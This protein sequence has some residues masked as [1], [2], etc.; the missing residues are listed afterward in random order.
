M[1]FF[2]TYKT[3]SAC[4][5]AVEASELLRGEENREIP[6]VIEE[7][8]EQYG[9]LTRTIKIIN[10]DGAKIMGRGIGSY[11]TIELPDLSTDTRRELS[12][13][14]ANALS[15]SLKPLIPTKDKNKPILLVGLGN[16]RMTA[17]ALGPWSIR[18]IQPTAHLMDVLPSTDKTET[19]SIAALIPGVL[20]NTGISTF[21]TVKAVCGEIKPLCVVAVDALSTGSLKR[22]GN[23]IQ[24]ADTGIRPGSGISNHNQAIS[25]ETLGVPVIAIGIPTVIHA[26]RIISEAIETCLSVPGVE[27]NSPSPNL[28]IDTVDELLDPYGGELLVTPK[29]IDGMIADCAYTVASGLVLA[30]HPG[31]NQT[32]YT[33]FLQ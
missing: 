4:D 28:I 9:L 30:L 21:S 22:I 5:M 31:A 18:H 20:G 13:S 15:Q 14:A 25:K 8:T 29:G 17:D 10:D 3:A 16:S 1:T 32:N 19:A 33:D 27:F 26:G 24:I 2:S 7:I 11:I 12:F 23:S 6:G